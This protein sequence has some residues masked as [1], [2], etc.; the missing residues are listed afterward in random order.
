MRTVNVKICGIT[1]EEDLKIVCDLGA[2]AVGFVV[3]V[4]SSPRS[5]SLYKAERLFRLVPK[6]V[7]SVLVT[8]PKSLSEI[9]EYCEHLKPDIIQIHGEK[10]QDF[11]F[12][13]ERFPNTI[14]VRALAIKPGAD[15]LEKV[16]QEEKF[17]DAVITDSFTVGKH[18]GTGLIHD[19][20]ISKRIRDAVYPKPLL[21]AGGL[22]PENV[23]EAIK[24]V[25]PYA[26]D[27]STGVESKLGIKDFRKVEAFIRNAK[28][29]ALEDDYPNCHW[30]R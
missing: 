26:V 19:W 3:E 6:R 2:D 21:L 10:V 9:I 23:K 18:G 11:K 13:K 16:I 24:T 27:V 12:L 30:L 17:S 22:T 1:S 8:V 7:K 29:V 4:L 28:K 20:S 25:K 5:L 15:A 14:L